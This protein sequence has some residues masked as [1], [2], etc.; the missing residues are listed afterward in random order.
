MICGKKTGLV[1]QGCADSLSIVFVTGATAYKGMKV[2]YESNIFKWE[3]YL[4][5]KLNV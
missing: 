5:Q 4:I 3:K 2:Y 1:F